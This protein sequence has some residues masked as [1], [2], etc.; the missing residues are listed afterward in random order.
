M[1]EKEKKVSIHNSSV[2]MARNEDQVQ[3]TVS[4]ANKLKS[5][6]SN[7]PV[8]WLAYQEL[9]RLYYSVQIRSVSILS[10]VAVALVGGPCL[11]YEHSSLR[12]KSTRDKTGIVGIIYFIVFLFSAQYT[13]FNKV[14]RT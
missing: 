4:R 9:S 13:A 1:S 7:L 5:V 10:P 11:S 12:L 8:D 3:S 14:P 2:I 6:I